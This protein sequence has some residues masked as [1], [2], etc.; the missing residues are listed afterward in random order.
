[1]IFRNIIVSALFLYVIFAGLMVPISFDTKSSATYVA[2]KVRYYVLEKC[3]ERKNK[4]YII[5]PKR[6]AEP[7][8]SGARAFSHFD[9]QFAVCLR[10]HN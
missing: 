9:V 2:F 5:A 1:M 10:A 8:Q 4:V 3:V 7:M 6:I